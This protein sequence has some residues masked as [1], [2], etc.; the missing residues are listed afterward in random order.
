MLDL[1]DGQK[2]W[3][4]YQEEGY[5]VV[6]FM[7]T[8]S[9]AAD[10]GRPLSRL[11]Q[12]RKFYCIDHAFNQPCTSHDEV[13]LSRGA[14][15]LPWKARIPYGNDSQWSSLFI[16]FPQTIPPNHTKPQTQMIHAFYKA[17]ERMVFLNI[18]Q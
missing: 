11:G 3:G 13:T 12:D 5:D 2:M 8:G 4:L 10:I 18:S 6:R 1:L 17:N 15:K 16:P 9:V 14:H 7:G